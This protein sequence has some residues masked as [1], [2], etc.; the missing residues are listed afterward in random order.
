ML[1]QACP[2][3]NETMDNSKVVKVIKLQVEDYAIE[4]DRRSM[5]M[6]F[7]SHDFVNVGS[8]YYDMPNMAPNVIQQIHERESICVSLGVLGQKSNTL[9]I[10]SPELDKYFIRPFHELHNDNQ[11]LT[12]NNS[13]LQFKN[14]EL[15]NENS[16]LEKD[17]MQLRN[18]N[19]Q[20]IT[21]QKKM[22]TVC[23][24]FW[25]RLVFLFTGKL[26]WL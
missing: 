14:K 1:A 12:T 7:R 11:I 8:N 2:M 18:F 6:R 26:I 5:S 3:E 10:C 9:V 17:N 20:L 23:N 22:Y 15:S 21:D 25:R 16:R 19:A 4:H 13:N 24:T